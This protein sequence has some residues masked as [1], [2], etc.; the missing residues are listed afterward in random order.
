MTG[1]QLTKGEY[2]KI[3]ALPKIKILK[4]ILQQKF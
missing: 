2:Y 1:L 3:G 4:T